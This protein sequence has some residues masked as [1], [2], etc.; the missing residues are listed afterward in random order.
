M[1]L[2][3]TVCLNKNPQC[4]LC[5]V[6]AHCLAR[7]NGTQNLFPVN[8][9]KQIFE[10]RHPGVNVCGV[11]S[12]PFAKLHDFDH[13]EIAARVRAAEPDIL[14][15]ALG[16]PKQEKWIYMHHRELGVPCSIG[17]GASLDFIAGRFS[18]APVWMQKSGLEWLYRLV[19]EPRRLWRRYLLRDP[20]FALI[21]LRQLIGKR[22]AAL[23]PGPASG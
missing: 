21:V 5:P 14:L 22:P 16:S 23:G 9:A 8:K 15:V 12:P 3:A 11:Y 19:R 13:A 10:Q 20:K 18:R 2:G 7:Q 4:L 6:A 1:E 17:I